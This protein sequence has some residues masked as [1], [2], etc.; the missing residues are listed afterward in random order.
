MYPYITENNL[1]HRQEY[2]YTAFDGVAFMR[3]YISGR[4]CAFKCRQ[5]DIAHLQGEMSDIIKESISNDGLL[6]LV[7][8]TF[9]VN[10]RLYQRYDWGDSI[11]S[12]ERIL[13][14]DKTSS[15][16]QIEDYLGFALALCKSYE[17]TQNLLYLNTLLKLNDTLLSLAESYM[18][19]GGG[20]GYNAL[21]SSKCGF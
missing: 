8:K 10:K 21:Y 5:Y 20:G 13:R 12:G 6:R 16:T 19:R 11:L 7:I 4:E 18:L 1:L 3:A 17:Y 9:E 14:P 2:N 15:Y